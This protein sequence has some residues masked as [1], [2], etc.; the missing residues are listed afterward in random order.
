M[1]MADAQQAVTD[2][3]QWRNRNVAVPTA[4][5]AARV[6]PTGTVTFL[7]TDIEGSTERW[8]AAGERMRAAVARHYGLLDRAVADHSGVRPIEQG[9]GDSLVAVFT[10]ASDAVAAALEAQCALVAEDGPDGADVAVRMALHTGEAQLR[11]DSF[12]VGPSV[13]RCARLRALAHGG[14]ILISSTTADLLAD[15]LPPGAALL[16]LG[17]HRLRD[18]R[19]PERVFQLTHP[20]LPAQFPMLR[21]LDVVPNNLPAQLTSFVG[22]EAALDEVRALLGEHRLVTLVGAGGC[23]KT[24]LASQVAAEIADDYPDGVWWVELASRSDPA[25]VARAV[26]AALGMGDTRGFDPLDRLT[27]YLADQDVLLVVDNCEH[28]VDSAARLVAELV[29]SCPR[30]TTLATSREPLSV[31]GEIAWRV[32]PLSLPGEER[33]SVN[34]LLASEAA[35]LFLDRAIEA[36]PSFHLDEGNVATVAAICTRL[37]GIPLAIELAAARVRALNPDRI[38][39]GLSDRFRLLTGGDRTALPRQQTLQASVEWSHE[40]LTDAERVLFRRLATFSGGF[41]LEAAEAVCAGDPLESWRVLTLLSDLVDKSLVVFDGDR[42]RLLQTVHDFAR[43]QLVGSGEAETVRNRHL[44]YFL[45]LAESA[46][47]ELERALHTKV[48]LSLEQDHDN[49]RAALGWAFDRHDTET[50]LRLVVALALFWTVHG[51]YSE[52]QAWHRRG[53]DALPPEPSPLRAKALW[54]LGHLSLYGMELATFCGVAITEEAVALARQLGDPDLLT[55]PL[56]DLGILQVFMVPT[57]GR[58]VLEQAIEAARARGDEWALATCLQWL[59]FCWIFTRDRFDLADPLLHAF[60]D[61]AVR[62]HNAH[63]LGWHDLVAGLGHW[64]RGKL[65]E[66]RTALEASL[67]VGYELADPMLEAY[68]A[69]FLID[70]HLGRGAVEQASSVASGTAERLHR[71]IDECRQSWVELGSAATAL[72][73]GDLPEARRRIE[74]FASVT[75]AWGIP[76]LLMRLNLLSGRAALED[77]NLGGA[78]SAFEEASEI[79]GRFESPWS[80]VEVGNCTGLLARA[81]GDLVAA[82]DRYHIA[83]ALTVQYGLRGLAAETLEALASLAHAAESHAEAARLYGAAQALREATGQRRWPL[84][85]PAYDTDLTALQSHLGDGFEQAWTEGSALTLEEAAA[86]ASRAR[87]E[88]KRPSTG[89]HAL[90]PTELQVVALATEG[91]SNAQIGERLFMAAGTAK[92][93]LSHIYAKLGVANRAQ[94]AAQA[95]AREL[96]AG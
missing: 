79:A 19:Q 16:P 50:A 42:Y 59:A 3:P 29:R 64:H 82:E 9:E 92:I 70:V 62:S 26:M 24:R 51:H 89:W 52:G 54:G 11:E 35:R 93:H 74:A 63:W 33:Q 84:D 80:L 69:G 4:S 6:L 91:L 90:T 43:G 83:L 30:V 8:E 47:T 56:I 31:S 78:R 23:G 87:G 10:R 1:A 96:G 60:H 12:Y 65:D 37:D 45:S 81:E 68:S 17:L 57:V 86:Y 28:V 41:R 85:Q 58:D 77:G 34:G 76:F 15:G 53:L 73:G 38:L 88:R 5:A 75:R 55:R 67:A 25:L 72:A 36:R 7:L 46:S 95:T 18:L 2:L 32:P 21:S 49:L 14:Q 13:I 94:L 27:Q 48:L 71:F 20:I 40:L 61:L 22:R 39:D 44:A 66:A